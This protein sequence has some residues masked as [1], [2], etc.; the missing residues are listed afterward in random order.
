MKYNNFKEHLYKCECLPS[1]TDA[2]PKDAIAGS[3]CVLDYCSDVNFCPRNTTCMNQEQQAI[4]QCDPGYVDIRKSEKRTQ[5]FDQDTLCLKMRDI[6]E[7]AL[8]ITN[9]SGLL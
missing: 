1:F 9:C 6:D 7:C 8:G 5:L 4:C 3:V 2:S